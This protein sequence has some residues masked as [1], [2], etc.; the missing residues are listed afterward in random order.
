MKSLIA[1]DDLTSRI[2]LRE[3]LKKFGPVETAADGK[4]AVNAFS[5]ALQAGEP[6]DLVCLDVMM[7][8]MDGYDVLREIRRLEEAQGILFSRGSTILMTTALDQTLDIMRA[9]Y[10][11]CDGYMP[12]PI[13]KGKV[14]EQLRA[15]E[16]IEEAAATAS[17]SAAQAGL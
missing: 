17:Q 11:V 4:Q 2:F 10:G 13:S 1:E 6:F 14:I 16:L 5:I 15:L 3:V 12:K 8:E 7:P 9:F